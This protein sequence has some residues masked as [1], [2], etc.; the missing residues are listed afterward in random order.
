MMDNLLLGI[1]ILLLGVMF[2]YFNSRLS[3][4]ESTMVKQNHVLSD[5]ITNVKSNTSIQ[6]TVQENTSNY[7]ATREAMHVAKEQHENASDME[8]IEVTD[9]ESE[10]DDSDST[11]DDTHT[12]EPI[13]VKVIRLGEIAD[14]HTLDT[15][16]TEHKVEVLDEEEDDDGI[17]VDIHD[18]STMDYSK[19]KVSQLRLIIADKGIV[20][21]G[22]KKLDLVNA[23]QENN[24]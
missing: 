15:L 12:V 6:E 17:T 9:S 14:G 21:K 10:D 1:C 19:M 24:L 2:Y 13:E 20:P 4:L 5:F 7:G 8:Y 16:F 22:K 3:I 18:G 23:L 11:P